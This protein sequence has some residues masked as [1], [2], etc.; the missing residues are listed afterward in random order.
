MAYSE[1][2][3]AIETAAAPVV[4]PND[5]KPT[6]GKVISAIEAKPSKFKVAI[7]DDHAGEIGPVVDLMRMVWRGHA[8][9]HGG[10]GPTKPQAEMAVHAASTLVQW[11][12][13]GAV[14]RTV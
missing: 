3:K 2:V 12:S 13:S 8:G 4:I 9:R 10:P 14:S 5:P 1:A 6:L 11:F 7:E